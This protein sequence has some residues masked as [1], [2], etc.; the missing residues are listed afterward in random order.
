MKEKFKNN[1]R[2]KKIKPS[3]LIDIM[4]QIEKLLQ[5][6]FNHLY[7]A[8]NEIQVFHPYLKS[9]FDL[10]SKIVYDIQYSSLSIKSDVTP[11]SIGVSTLQNTS[12]SYNMNSK[13][14]NSTIPADKIVKNNTIN[15]MNIVGKKT[16]DKNN[17]IQNTENDTS[18]RTKESLFPNIQELNQ[19]FDINKKIFSSSELIKYKIIYE[20]LPIS[21]LI[22]VFKDICDNLKK[23]I[24]N[25]KIDYDSDASDFEESNIFE[26]IKN[27]HHD[28]NT[29]HIVN[30]KIFGLKKFE[31]NYK[32]FMELLK[33]YL[34]SFEIIENEIEVEIEN[35]NRKKQIELGEEL[36]ILYN[37][38]EDAVY[39]KMDRLDDD[40]IFNRKV[41]L[42]LLLNHREYLSIIFDI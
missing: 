6:V 40:D 25:S 22:T 23:T 5:F 28:N 9:I 33:N 34:V 41:L 8:E 3:Q 17:K 29:Y 11:I 38:F 4:E 14:N 42:K 26:E 39:F 32:I 27:S 30:Q 15:N 16:D 35:K 1:H 10:I 7:K 13:F 37:I 36:K 18:S 31:F 20:G 2:D 24:Y 21:N 12:L 19:F